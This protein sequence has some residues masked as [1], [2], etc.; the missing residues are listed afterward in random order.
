ML[1]QIHGGWCE[2]HFQVAVPTTP[3]TERHNTSGLNWQATSFTC[4]AW[5][6][7][8]EKLGPCRDTW[9]DDHI[10]PRSNIGV[11]NSDHQAF[12]FLTTLPATPA[13]VLAPRV[14]REVDGQPRRM[15]QFVKRV[16]R[17]GRG[18][19]HEHRTQLQTPCKRFCHIH[20]RLDGGHL[21]KA[22]AGA[23]LIL[24]LDGVSY[25]NAEKPAFGEPS[26]RE[27]AITNALHP[28]PRLKEKPV[29]TPRMR[30]C[31]ECDLPGLEECGHDPRELDQNSSCALCGGIVCHQACGPFDASR[32]LWPHRASLIV[33]RWFAVAPTPVDALQ[34]ERWPV[35]PTRS[36][37]RRSMAG[38][39]SGSVELPVSTNWS[40]EKD[41][42][43]RNSERQGSAEHARR[44]AKTPV[45]HVVLNQ[46]ILRLRAI[47][48]KLRTV[49]CSIPAIVVSTRVARSEEPRSFQIESG[50]GR[51][52]QVVKFTTLAPWLADWRQRPRREICIG[53]N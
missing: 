3:T 4:G 25:V 37:T 23:Q 7:V 40:F 29:A 34:C 12:H 49:H 36:S 43:L 32:P 19:L 35:A 27:D 48:W 21:G 39:T 11:D 5:R 30:A 13:V 9:R 41:A 45:R 52:Q 15:G 33:R 14:V 20:V 28:L 1:S 47:R 31:S 17:T 6:D 46:K 38:G 22:T 50:W 51:F 2:D 8:L 18:R 10:S 44:C 42:S 24:L 26:L 53:W 16:K